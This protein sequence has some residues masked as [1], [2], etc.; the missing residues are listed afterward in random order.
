MWKS[1]VGGVVDGCGSTV[2]VG[3]S[4][5]VGVA[6]G[7]CVGGCIDGCVGWG[8]GAVV[9]VD[10]DVVRKVRDCDVV[11]V[12]LAAVVDIDVD[13]SVVHATTAGASIRRRRRGIRHPPTC[14]EIKVLAIISILAVIWVGRENNT[15]Q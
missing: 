9:D 15:A 6:I 13:V 5:T 4:G 12:M 11:V 7:G 14:F 8:I 2:G 1:T 10:G 3:D